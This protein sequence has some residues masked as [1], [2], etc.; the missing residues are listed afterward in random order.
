MR[1]L[2]PLR[3]PIRRILL[4]IGCART[5]VETHRHA[6]PVIYFA[7]SNLRLS[8]NI[9]CLHVLLRTVALLSMSAVELRVC[10]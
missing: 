2:A 8:I 4:F 6:H 1:A 5:P 7:S 9:E 3:L 10:T